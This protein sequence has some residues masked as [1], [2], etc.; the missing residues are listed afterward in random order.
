MSV[1]RESAE[2][3]RS[4]SPTSPMPTS[5]TSTEGFYAPAGSSPTLPRDNGK[6][7]ELPRRLLELPNIPDDDLDDAICKY[8]RVDWLRK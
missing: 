1:R 6:P 4:D 8:W 3:K 2:L 7:I 5:T